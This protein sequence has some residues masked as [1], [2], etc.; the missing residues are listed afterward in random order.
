MPVLCTNYIYFV[1]II[2]SFIGVLVFVPG[3][4]GGVIEEP[5]DQMSDKCR[6]D[7]QLP[8]D[9]SNIYICVVQ[10]CDGRRD[11]PGGED[12]LNCLDLP[13]EPNTTSSPPTKA[14]EIEGEKQIANFLG[15]N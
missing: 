4:T 12:E 10:R 5:L 3:G 11:C 8:C 13:V 9:N 6:G 7:D 15:G 2:P 14:P 1:H